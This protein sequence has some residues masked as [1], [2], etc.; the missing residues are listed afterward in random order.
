MIIF[1]NLSK[2][3]PIYNLGYYFSVYFY[4]YSF[5]NGNLFF[6]FKLYY[7]NS[8]V[9]DFNIFDA[10]SYG[11]NNNVKAATIEA[12]WSPGSTS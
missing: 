6:P 1:S 4:S 12:L 9:C 8:L 7:N 11:T 10:I 2:F 3:N 5:F